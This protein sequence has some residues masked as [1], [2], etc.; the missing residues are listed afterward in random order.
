MSRRWI[1]TAAVAVSAT[2]ISLFLLTSSPAAALGTFPLDCRGGGQLSLHFAQLEHTLYVRFQ[3]APGPAGAGL[4]PGQCSWLDRAFRPGEPFQICDRGIT[5]L[6][7][8]WGDNPTIAL[9]QSSTR[10]WYLDYI[11]NS[12]AVVRFNVYNEGNCMRLV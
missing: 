5:D 12:Q 7:M 9:Q 8:W 3:P 6:N 11:R 2:L 4:A 10:G 1:R